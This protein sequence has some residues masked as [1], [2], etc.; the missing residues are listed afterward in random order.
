[1]ALTISILIGILVAFALTIVLE[2]YSMIAFGL[3][4]GI[5]FYQCIK[6]FYIEFMHDFL[7]NI[8]YIV[9]AAFGITLIAYA[10]INCIMEKKSLESA[11]KCICR[12][13]SCQQTSKRVQAI[14]RYLKIDEKDFELLEL[15]EQL[16]NEDIKK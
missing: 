12:C 1:M 3:F 11:G 4:K 16:D 2:L 10:S 9:I 6:A 8:K 14:I 13:Q 15:L 7:T 5:P